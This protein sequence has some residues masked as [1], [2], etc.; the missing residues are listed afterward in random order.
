MNQKSPTA[1][2]RHLLQV[3]SRQSPMRDAQTLLHKKATAFMDGKKL[4]QGIR[5]WQKWVQFLHHHADNLI[6]HVTRITVAGNMVTVH[7]K[8]RKTENGIAA[9]SAEGVVIYEVRD[10]QIINIWTHRKNYI[11]IYG[12]QIAENKVAFWRLIA[13]LFFW[14]APD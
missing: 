7:A 1:T 13:R 12:P 4:A 5:S 2:V 6:L 3:I 8:W 11:F 14:R 9:E 10:G